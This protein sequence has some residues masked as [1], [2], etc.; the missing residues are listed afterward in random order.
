MM[1]FFNWL[2]DDLAFY[3]SKFSKRDN[4]NNIYNDIKDKD[5]FLD[6]QRRGR[7]FSYHEIDLAICDSQEIN[8][9]SSLSSYQGLRYDLRVTPEDRAFKNILAKFNKNI[10]RAFYDKFLYLVIKNKYIEKLVSRKEIMNY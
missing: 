3:Y 5:L 4:F 8:V 6:F 1:P 2:P 7:G 10:D 9:I